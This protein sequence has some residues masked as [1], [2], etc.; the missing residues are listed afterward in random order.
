MPLI[1]WHPGA[2][3]GESSEPDPCLFIYP[4]VR[5]FYKKPTL[6]SSAVWDSSSLLFSCS[7]FY[8]LAQRGPPQCGILLLSCSPAHLSTFSR[9]VVLRSV[10]YSVLLFTLSRALLN[11][12]VLNIIRFQTHLRRLEPDM[13]TRSVPRNRETPNRGAT[14]IGVLR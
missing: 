7:P 9:S 14:A 6:R 2:A 11:H 8:F 3:P 5:R 4:P 10:G 13:N 1:G 12:T